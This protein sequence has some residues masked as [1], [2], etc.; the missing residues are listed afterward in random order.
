LTKYL[1]YL[2]SLFLA[3]GLMV[4]DGILD[5]QS[6]AAAYDQVSYAQARK[7]FRNFKTSQYNQITS[8]EKTSLSIPL[9][10]LHLQD[11]CSLK[12]RVLLK[13]RIALYQN[14]SAIKAQQIFLSKIITSSNPYSSLYI[15]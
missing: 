13:S 2:F 10:Q 7:D 12:T 9:A 8:S 1:K 3:F 14:I 11:I 15:G 6:N 4:N 5:S